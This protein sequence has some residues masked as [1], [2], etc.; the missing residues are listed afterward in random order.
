M[1]NYIKV[2]ALKRV[3]VFLILL[4]STNACA[5]SVLKIDDTIEIEDEN[6]DISPGAY[7]TEEYIPLLENKR[8]AIVGNQTSR[9]E[10][11]HL[12]DSLLS[13]KVNIVKVFSPE[14]GFRGEGD[15]GAKINDAIDQKTKLPVISIY[16]DNKK[17]KSKD[18]DSIDYILFDL[19]DVGVRFYTYISTLHYVMEAAAEKGIK[20]I[21]LDRP[22]PNGHIIDGPTRKPGFE[23][24]VGMHPVP[25]LYGMTI[26]EYGL[27]INGEKWLKD[28]LTCNLTVIEIKDYK[29]KD[30]YSLP[31]APSPNLKNDNSI[32]LYP[33]LCFFEGTIVSVGRGTTTP[34]EIFG[35]PDFPETGFSFTPTSQ[36]G[37][38]DPKLKNQKCNGI[39]LTENDERFK[40]LSLDYLFQAR[41][42]LHPKYGDKWIDRTRFFNLLAG[43]DELAKQLNS[44]ISEDEIRESWEEDIKTFRKI[45]KEY[46]IYR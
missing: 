25:V 26:G 18:L 28:S 3:S 42:I 41:D 31:I 8:V 33:S 38:T 7:Q 34:F 44:F 29:R 5:S 32:V 11:T 23:S 16:G 9:I 13:R 20:V 35:H 43:N 45:R 1:L 10:N 14:H 17:P 30:E 46:L 22:N 6:G 27:M 39:N 36:V 40:K 24:F 15:A 37:A 2:S 4:Y 12:V 19:Q 21:I